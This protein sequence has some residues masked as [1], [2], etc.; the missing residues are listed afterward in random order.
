VLGLRPWLDE[1]DL[2]AGAE[3]ERAVQAGMKASCAAVF[4]ITPAFSDV[5]Y[6]RA[7]INY[8]ITEKRQRAEAFSV[9]TLLIRDEKATA[10]RVPELLEPYV[11]KEPATS[12]QGL[13]EILRALPPA[14]QGIGPRSKL[15]N[16]PDLRVHVRQGQLA[17]TG[18]PTLDAVSVTIEN[19]DSVPIF[20]TGGASADRRMRPA[21]FVSARRTW[22][23]VLSHQARARGGPLRVAASGALAI[24]STALD[25]GCNA[26]DAQSA[27]RDDFLAEPVRYSRTG[28]D[29]QYP[30]VIP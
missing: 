11:W 27:C 17:S 7:V 25:S 29:S 22:T 20:L 8:A 24:S 6:L 30:F 14:L 3:L 28:N 19:H 4:F 18:Q 16:T 23:G 12:L 21:F 2:P 13:R 26:G 5:W 1:D 10:G 15:T 9:I